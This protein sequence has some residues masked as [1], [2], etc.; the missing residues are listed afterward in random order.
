MVLEEKI[1]NLLALLTARAGG[2]SPMVLVG[3]RPPTPALA[4][5]AATEKKRRKGKATEGSKKGEIPQPVQQALAKEPK[6]TT[7]HQK[8]GVTVGTGKGIEGEQRPK[9]IIWNLAF[10]LISGDPVTSEASLRDPQK[11]RSRL[12]LECLE[13]ALL[14]PED[15]QELQGLRKREVFLSLKR[16]LAK[17][18]FYP[19]YLVITLCLT[20]FDQYTFFHLPEVEKGRKNAEVALAG[21]E[22]Q[23][24]ELQVSLKKSETQLALAME[25]TKQQQKQ[26]E[27]KDAEKAKAEQATYDARKTKTAQSLIAQLKDVAQAFCVEV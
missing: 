22:K 3:L 6:T 18:R 19:L 25:K 24:E 11:G 1:P 5:V 26:L 16:G 10:V 2:N 15:M 13:K 12:V 27:D 23:A 21:F 20:L 17:V 9:P 7:A 8:K 4:Q 14:L